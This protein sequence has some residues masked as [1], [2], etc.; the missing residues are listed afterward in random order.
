MQTRIL[1]TNIE[2]TDAIRDYLDKKL[3]QVEKYADTK[4]SVP[5]VDVE[6]GKKISDQNTGDDLFRA[7]INIEIGGRFYRYV[8]EESELYAAI[9]KMKDEIVRI[10][11]K[12]KEK[13]TDGFR[14]GAL[15]MKNL[16]LGLGRKK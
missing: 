4:N 8:A 16:I 14:R 9:D 10:L 6:I 2:L 1:A 3:S 11:R 5:I 13:K 12:D 7:E 15:R